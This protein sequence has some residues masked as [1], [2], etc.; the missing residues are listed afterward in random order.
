MNN[1][2]ALLARHEDKIILFARF[3]M[4][5]M[6]IE[7]IVDKLIHWDFYVSE[8]ATKGIPL[9][10]IAL[11]LAVATEIFGS[12]AL[13]TGKFIRLGAFLLAGYVFVLGFFYFDFWNL[14]GTNAIMARKEFLKDLAVIAGLFLFVVMGAGRFRL[15]YKNSHNTH[16]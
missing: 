1:M 7:S 16:S 9:A 2:S 5:L 11:G 3:L 15:G 4:A 6:F 14:E 10:A 12:I 13:L 8:T